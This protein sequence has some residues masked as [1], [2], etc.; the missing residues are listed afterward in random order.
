M[1]H[2]IQLTLAEIQRKLNAPKNQHNDY[3]N[4]NYRN[5]EGIIAA[6]KSIALDDETLVL[7]DEIV[8]VGDR[9]F[10]KSTATLTVSDQSISADGWAQHA[11][12]K[13]GMDEAQ[14]TGSCSSYARKYALC[15]L[16]AIDDSDQDPDSKDNRVKPEPEP[17]TEQPEI[18]PAELDSVTENINACQTMDELQK[19]W[20]ALATNHKHIA[21]HKDII[22]AK[23][24]RKSEIQERS[25]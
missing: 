16:F 1:S 17:K 14:V 8:S 24:V 23:D 20:V 6:F 15:G 5:A 9:I 7:S 4:Y 13:K 11:A 19:F 10:L 21:A 22:A 18:T 2:K 25:Q 12:N 3:G